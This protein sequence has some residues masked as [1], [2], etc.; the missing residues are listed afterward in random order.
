MDILQPLVLVLINRADVLACLVEHIPEDQLAKDITQGVKTLRSQ[1]PALLEL[2]DL[3]MLPFDA[4]LTP[5]LEINS[6]G[7][8]WVKRR[9]ELVSVP[10]WTKQK[11]VRELFFFLLC[12]PEGT[13]RDEICLEFWPDSNPQQLKKQFKNALY[14]LRRAVGPD[15][16]LFDQPTRLYHFNRDL[17]FRFDVAVG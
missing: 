8:V 2:L 9:G 1:L 7:R 6:L 4:T 11:T 3:N 17:D 13:S 12:R 15:S 14:R 16:I 10:E 5:Y